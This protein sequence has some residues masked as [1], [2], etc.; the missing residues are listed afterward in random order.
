V[1]K[2]Q[3]ASIS[4]V[5]VFPC[6]DTSIFRLDT[7]KRASNNMVPVLLINQPPGIT[8]GGRGMAGQ[9]PMLQS[10]QPGWLLAA[11]LL[12]S[13]GKA[14]GGGPQ[15]QR[16]WQ[17]TTAAEAIFLYVQQCTGGA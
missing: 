14:H 13:G 8:C 12:S 4:P 2:G 10:T 1:G 17:Q 6:L 5:D 7:T 16:K 15:Q 11:W 3:K 9:V